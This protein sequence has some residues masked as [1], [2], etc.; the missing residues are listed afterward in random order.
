MNDKKL[1]QVFH[2]DLYG[3][4]EEKYEFLNQKSLV[5]LPWTIISLR[6]SSFLYIESNDKLWSEYLNY[7]NLKDI[8]N[9]SSSGV[10]THDDNRLVSFNDFLEYNQVYAYRPFDLRNIDYDLQKVVRHRYNTIKHLLLPNIALV[11]TRLNRGLSSGYCFI[12]NKLLDV[13]L[14]DSAADS[15][16]CFPLYYYPEP[17]LQ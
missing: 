7:I 11:T 5:A 14:L 6:E 15:L 1:A 13:H 10:K 12:T 8:F 16:Q 3:K 17:S 4:R 9:H 2:Y